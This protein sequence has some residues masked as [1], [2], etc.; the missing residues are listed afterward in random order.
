MSERY[1]ERERERTGDEILDHEHVG[2]RT[3]RANLVIL[4][5]FGQTRQT[6]LSFDVHRTRTANTLTARSTI[7]K[8]RLSL[9]SERKSRILLVLD[10][11][12][13]IQHHGSTTA[14]YTEYIP[15]LVQI[16]NVFL[17]V[18]LD[19]LIRV[20]SEDREQLVRWLFHELK[21]EAYTLFCS[22]PSFNPVAN[23]AEKT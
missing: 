12:Q 22:P 14:R 19:V 11:E 13:S 2:Q 5:D 21:P 23:E 3:H 9:P 18:R 4:G 17:I 8:I 7:L 15:L 20:V 10:L 16:N 6:V 1:V